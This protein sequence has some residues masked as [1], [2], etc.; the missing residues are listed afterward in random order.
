MTVISAFLG[1]A[2]AYSLG[3]SDFFLFTLTLVG[4]ILL[5][6]AANMTNDYYDVKH[7]VDRLGAATTRYRPHPLALG[8]VTPLQFRGVILGL[9]V[10]SLLIATYLALLRGPVVLA[11]AGAGFF[12]ST[13]YTADPLRLKHRALGELVVFAMWG[14]LMTWGTF[15]VVSGLTNLDV[16]LASAP[17]GLLVSLVLFANNMRDMQYDASAKVTTAAA[18]LGKAGSVA[19]FKAILATAYLL[20]PLLVLSRILSPWCLL[21]FISAP[22]AIGL[23]KQFSVSIP[24]TADPMVAQLTTLFG[25]LLVAGVLAGAFLPL[26]W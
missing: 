4:L 1:G 9:Y 23:A 19:V 16:M 13:F 17:I 14:P 15:L 7:G 20:V 26:G 25:I 18:L 3:Y 11:L 8:E 6:A 10:S 2:L 22:K 5:H 12:F 24:D 21:V